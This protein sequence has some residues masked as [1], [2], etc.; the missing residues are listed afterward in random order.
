MFQKKISSNYS[1]QSHHQSPWHPKFWL[2]KKKI[3]SFCSYFVSTHVKKSYFILYTD[4]LTRKVNIFS[5]VCNVIKVSRHFGVK[6]IF[7]TDV[8]E[9]TKRFS[10]S[11]WH[12]C[13]IINQLH[14]RILI[15]LNASFYINYGCWKKNITIIIC[16]YNVFPVKL[17]IQFH[18]LVRNGLRVPALAWGKWD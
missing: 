10:S 9:K 5:L 12:P 15:H 1:E 11:F 8:R 7:Y 16:T 4:I 3:K 14:I 6:C 18:F 17:N 2:P 13:R